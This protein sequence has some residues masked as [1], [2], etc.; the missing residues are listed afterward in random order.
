MCS[1][2]N[3]GKGTG[4]RQ[5][6]ITMPANNGQLK[7]Q[8]SGAADELRAN[9]QLKSS[10]YSVPGLGLIFLRYVV[11][12]AMPLLAFSQSPVRIA[13]VQEPPELT[14]EPK[15]FTPPSE[16]MRQF[17]DALPKDEKNIEQV[18][19]GIEKLSKLLQ[20]NPDYSDGYFMRALFNRCMLKS[21]DSEAILK[22]INTAMSTHAAQKLPGPYESL[23][24]HYSFRAKVWFD[25][26]RYSEALDD[27]E[28]AMMQRIDNADK[29]FGSSGIKPDTTSPNVC[30]WSLSD[31]DTLVQRFPKD[32]RALLFRGLY[33]EYF[34][35]FDEKYVID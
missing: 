15:K 35:K 11:L 9:S 17:V 20:E 6:L 1:T 30:I 33:L 13:G 5:P 18:K 22:D 10:E 23:A 34:A 3:C 2:R 29:L 28:A 4:F 12:A 8:L 27:L 32:Y 26:G 19:S 24:E 16:I 7:K 14:G 31:L 25:R 21:D